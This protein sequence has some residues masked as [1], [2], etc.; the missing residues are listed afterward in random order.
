MSLAAYEREEVSRDAFVR[1]LS[2]SIQALEG[3]PDRV[4]YELRDHEREIEIEG[5]LE[6]EEF[7]ANTTQAKVSLSIWLKS[8]KSTYCGGD[9]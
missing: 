8:L 9:C 4:R 2:S 5:Y 6:D 7:E 1:F 3:V